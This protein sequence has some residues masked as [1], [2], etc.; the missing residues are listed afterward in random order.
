MMNSWRELWYLFGFF[1][2]YFTFWSGRILSLHFW[3]QT[4]RHLINFTLNRQDVKRWVVCSN[5]VSTPASDSAAVHRRKNAT[6]QKR[7]QETRRLHVMP[8]N[9][10]ILQI[11][12]QTVFLMSLSNPGRDY[13][14]VTDN[15]SFKKQHDVVVLLKRL[16]SC[17]LLSH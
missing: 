7:G 1:F 16:A 11:V 4:E 17:R 8:L 14:S 13:A 12:M 10:T 15:I 2:F 9:S 5:Q 6:G 3:L